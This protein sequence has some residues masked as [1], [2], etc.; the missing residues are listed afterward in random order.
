MIRQAQ[1]SNQNV[2]IFRLLLK[3]TVAWVFNVRLNHLFGAPSGCILLQRNSFELIY[4]LLKNERVPSFSSFTY[5]LLLTFENE[6]RGF[7]V[8]G[9]WGFGEIGRAHV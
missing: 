7:G 2:L 5:N 9:F 3:I 4:T 1:N 8:L 6:Q